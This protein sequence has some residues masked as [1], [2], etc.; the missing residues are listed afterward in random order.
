MKVALV[1]SFVP[2]VLGGGR[3]IVDWL[4]PHLEAAGHEVEV[5]YLPFVENPDH[6]FSQLAAFRAIDLTDQ[7]DV[8]VCFRV[9]AHLVRHPRKVLW[10]IHHF[11]VWY[12]L[13]DTDY[14]G[15]PATL[16]N[17]ARRERLRQVDTRAFGE[18][19]RIFTNSSIVAARLKEFNGFDGEVLF[20]PVAEPGRFH[21]AV[22]GDSIVYLARLEHHKRQHLLVEALALCTT[23]VR[24]VIVGTGSSPAYGDSLRTLA[25]AKGVADRVTIDDRWVSEEGK[26]RVLSTS[27]AVAYLPLDEDSYGYPSLEASHSSKPIL[28]TTD[29]G[30][31]LEL[32]EDGVNGL[33]VEPTP[34]AVAAA[35][36]ELYRDRDRTAQM[37][38]AARQRLIDMRIDW[39]NV[40]D[41]LLS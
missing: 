22:Y 34:Q 6:L 13:W 16:A 31:V 21:N 19:H 26:V 24:L 35:M 40:V 1:S 18:A 14:R 33:V 39:D 10:F 38:A 3:N 25:A 37:G 5:I 9:P 27:L 15:F 29:S 36:D 4:V 11:R 41:R 32:V 7:A 23:E 28:T 20:P 17:R 8:V 2:F 12:D 30:G